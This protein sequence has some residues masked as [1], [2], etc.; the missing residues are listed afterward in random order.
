[1]GTFRDSLDVRALRFAVTFPLL[2][3]AAF[4]GCALL[5]RG[6]LPDPL[7][8][9]WNAD[10]GSAFAPFGVYVGGGA[11]LI[12]AVG[13]AIFGQA[14]PIAR[15]VIMRRI[16]MGL[17]LMASL[18]MTSVLAAGLVGQAGLADARESRVDLTVLGLGCG[19]ALGLGV[20]MMFAFKPDDRW[21]P[22][23]DRALETELALNSDPG[24][25]E[26]SIKLW[27]HARSSVFVMIC[28]ASLFPAALIAIAVPWLAVVVVAAAVI[29]AA[30]L[31]A[32]VRADRSGLQVFVAGALRVLDV[33]AR[34]IAGASAADVKAADFGGW[35]FRHHDGSTAMLVSS[36]PAVVVRRV[37]GRRI[38]LSAGT[39]A[40]ADKLASLLNRIAARAQRDGRPP[41]S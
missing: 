19:A 11:A 26:D 8:I 4:A 38:A 28:V 39:A 35:G 14:V 31:F 34:D 29:G 30:F 33:P 24:L 32:R 21:T 27:V 6:D 16:M 5:L 22:E 13:W 37:N 7:A 20:V 10:G 18:F 41:E 12:T 3:A 2:L 25:A 23:D 17:G 40:T 9:G 36:G 15:P 1:M